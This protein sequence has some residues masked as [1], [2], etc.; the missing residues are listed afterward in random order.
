MKKGIGWRL[1]ALFFCL[2]FLVGGIQASAREALDINLERD[3]YK[4]QVY[5]CW[6]P[7][8][9]WHMPLLR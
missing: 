8:E 4:R 6:Q 5:G 3:V 9:M 2:W 1:C 7:E